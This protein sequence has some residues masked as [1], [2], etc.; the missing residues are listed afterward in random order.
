MAALRAESW[1]HKQGTGDRECKCGTWKQHW[2]NISTEK[3]PT[4]CSIK[5]CNNLATDGAHV[6]NEEEHGEW[7]VPMCRS[8][9]D[10]KNDTFDLKGNVFLVPANKSKTCEQ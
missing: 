4:T 5:G 10:K 6:I 2:I 1:K 9:N 3:W 7:I 8:C